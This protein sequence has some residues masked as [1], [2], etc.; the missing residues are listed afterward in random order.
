MTT[1][2]TFFSNAN[3]PIASTFFN[4][5]NS[6]SKSGNCAYI[7]LGVANKITIAI[8]TDLNLKDTN[9]IALLYHKV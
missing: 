6:K 8:N 7:M 1:Q 4:F 9:F 2:A 5:S 3:A